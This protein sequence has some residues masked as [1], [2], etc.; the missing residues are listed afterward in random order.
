MCNRRLKKQGVNNKRLALKDLQR[1]ILWWTKSVIKWSNIRSQTRNESP[2]HFFIG[3]FQ[4]QGATLTVERTRLACLSCHCVRSWRT[5]E[6]VGTSDIPASSAHQKNHPNIKWI[7]F[8]QLEKST[9]LIKPWHK[10][11]QFYWVVTCKETIWASQKHSI[12]NWYP[13]Q[14]NN[15]TV[16]P[17]AVSDPRKHRNK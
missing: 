17:V 16:P 6:T 10:I 13:K 7:S 3:C 8:Y 11:L 15:P 14:S 12:K 2:F 5:F 4:R 1:E 9:I